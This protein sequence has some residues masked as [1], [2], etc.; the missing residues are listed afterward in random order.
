MVRLARVELATCCFG[1]NRS[2]QLSYSRTVFSVYSGSWG[3]A[4]ELAWRGWAE[5]W[6][7]RLLRGMVE[8]GGK[9]VASLPHSKIRPGVARSGATRTV[10][11]CDGLHPS[12]DDDRFGFFTRSVA[13]QGFDLFG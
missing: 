1:G 8:F 11:G 12:E 2:I 3:A 7:A 4:K 5:L 13:G 9:A 10:K 6:S